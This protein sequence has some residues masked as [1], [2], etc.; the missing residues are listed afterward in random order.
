MG[1]GPK[2]SQSDRALQKNF[3]P[4]SGR[5]VERQKSLP[6]FALTGYRS[7]PVSHRLFHLP[8]RICT[9]LK[10]T[11]EEMIRQ[12][13]EEPVFA[14][15]FYKFLLE[16]SVRTRADLVDQLF[17]C[18]EK[19]LARVLL[20]MAHFGKPGEWETCIPP[21]THELLA[22]MIGTARSRVSCFMNRFRKLGFID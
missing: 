14:D 8:V 5:L 3:R 19:R 1:I 9:A 18:S 16:R 6:W 10:I 22:E 12:L 7:T 17:N 11:R 2:Y 13:H 15:F 21:I 4:L 20:L